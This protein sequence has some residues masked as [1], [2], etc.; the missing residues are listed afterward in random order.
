MA[1]NRGMASAPALGVLAVLTLGAS[2]A[3]V[4][5][6]VK[7]RQLT[8]AHQR[9]YAQCETLRMDLEQKD[10][11]LVEL[12]DRRKADAAE[13]SRLTQE[14][15]GHT[16]TITRL[17]EQV[18][19]LEQ[20]AS[21]LQA[22]ITKAQA[23]GHTKEAT[24]ADLTKRLDD[25]RA[26][27]DAAANALKAMGYTKNELTDQVDKLQA[28]LAESDRSLADL[29]KRTEEQERAITKLNDDL[30]ARGAAL[31]SLQKEADSLRVN[32]VALE[33]ELA[34]RPKPSPFTAVEIYVPS[35]DR[36]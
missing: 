25:T 6:G 3:A 23:E 31:T 13:I 19:G 10:R 36:K 5:L 7:E 28:R 20:Q 4:W 24:V 18:G 22:E 26:Q 29:R 32:K 2:G 9:L 34:S 35:R 15:S 8:A 16:A 33:Q 30:F 14:A 27:A 12:S 1:Q 21:A 11:A 17:R